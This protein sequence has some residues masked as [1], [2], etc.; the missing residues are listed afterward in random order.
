MERA[1]L[2]DATGT[3]VGNGSGRPLVVYRVHL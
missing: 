3:Q 1:G 2:A